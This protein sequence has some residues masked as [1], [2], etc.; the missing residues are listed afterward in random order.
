MDFIINYIKPNLNNTP[1]SQT[2]EKKQPLINTTDLTKSTY[3]NLI[4]LFPKERAEKT[5]VIQESLW[6]QFNFYLRYE[7]QTKKQELEE[8]KE[9]K[10]KPKFE[11]Y[12][13]EMKF[14]RLKDF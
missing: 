5:V 6:H 13:R 9:K 1:Q 14:Y 11:E 8:L 12:F 10:G 7:K 3:N 4:E 2:M